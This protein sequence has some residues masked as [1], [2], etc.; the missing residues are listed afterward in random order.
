[1]PMQKALSE[2]FECPLCE[3]DYELDRVPV[4][5]RPM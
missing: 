4:Q 1:M 2:Y 5:E 3:E